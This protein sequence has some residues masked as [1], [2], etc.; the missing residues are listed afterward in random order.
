MVWYKQNSD[1]CVV[2]SGTQGMDVFEGDLHACD[3]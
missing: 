3:L 2:I 1:S